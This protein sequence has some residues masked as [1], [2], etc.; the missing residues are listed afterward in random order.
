MILRARVVG[1]ALY[2][3]P[4]AVR[5]ESSEPIWTTAIGRVQAVQIAVAVLGVAA[6][7]LDEAFNFRVAVVTGRTVALC[8]MVQRPALSI[9]TADVRLRARVVAQAGVTIASFVV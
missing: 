8:P 5:S 6:G 3:R 7:S 2:P 9:L 1:A 4:D